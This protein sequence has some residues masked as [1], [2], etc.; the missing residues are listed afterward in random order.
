MV[1]VAARP[2]VARPAVA[3][4]V[5]AVRTMPVVPLRPVS[6][7]RA[8]TPAVPSPLRA[9]RRVPDVPAAGWTGSRC[10]PTRAR[11]RDAAP[12]RRA[13]VRGRLTTTGGSRPGR[14]RVG[15]R[16]DRRADDGPGGHGVHHHLDGASRAAPDPAPD[17][18]AHHHRGGRREHAREDVLTSRHDRSP[19]G[20]PRRA[21]SRTRPHR[22]SPPVL[23]TPV[24]RRR[25]RA[26][27]RGVVEVP[28][29]PATSRS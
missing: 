15:R 20:C 13:A 6:A 14:R 1:P 26:G 18:H 17:D 5:A 21:D 28:R 4:P 19:H 3:R 2:V 8:V 11:A 7:D 24:I 25:N 23:S 12:R 22:S 9:G 10:R 16:R 29:P 27:G